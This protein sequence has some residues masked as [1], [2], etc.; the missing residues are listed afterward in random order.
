MAALYTQCSGMSKTSASR[1]GSKNSGVRA[2]VQ[3]W[4]FS[5][6]ADLDLDEDNKPV[7]TLETS[8]DSRGSWGN[9]VY[10]G[11]GADFTTLLNLVRQ[12][13]TEEVIKTLKKKVSK[14]E[15]RAK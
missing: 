14:K 7:L 4:D 11:T 1:R 13:G 6:I 9:T 12:L 15:K 3:S 5:L 10:R 8:D 2:S